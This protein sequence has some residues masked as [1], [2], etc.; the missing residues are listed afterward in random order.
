MDLWWWTPP[1]PKPTKQFTSLGIENSLTGHRGDIRPRLQKGPNKHPFFLSQFSIPFDVNMYVYIFFYMIFVSILQFLLVASSGSYIFFFFYLFIF[2]FLSSCLFSL[3][4]LAILKF[5]CQRCK[6]KYFSV[7]IWRDK[8]IFTKSAHWADSVIE[9]RGPS[10][11]LSVCLYVCDKSK[12]A[13][14]EIVETFG[15]RA[16]R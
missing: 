11:C 14:P 10:A 6:K 13:L 8:E 12:H 7:Q 9:S 4:F 15:Q 16:Y 3:L 5:G 1:H 2:F